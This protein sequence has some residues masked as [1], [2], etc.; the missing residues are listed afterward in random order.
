M[1]YSWGFWLGFHAVLFTL[2][3]L[4]LFLFRR[5]KRKEGIQAALGWSCFWIALSLA[6]NL[7]IY[8]MSGSESAL[9][10]FTGYVIE[11]SLSIDN[12]FVFLLIF[13]SLKI[14][15]EHQHKIL[16]GGVFGALVFRLCLILLGVVGLEK[17][18]W[19]YY[20][21]GSFLCLTA[22]RFALDA[23]EKRGM[24]GNP[25]Y[26]LAVR[27]LPLASDVREG[28]FFLR[29]NGKLFMTSSFL[30]LILI[31]TA[32]IIFALDSIPAILAIT[33]NPF[34]VY[35]SNIFAILGLRSLYFV[36]A[37]FQERMR[38]FTLG[39]ALILF[40]IGLKMLLSSWVVVS[41]GLSL[42]VILSILALAIVFSVYCPLKKE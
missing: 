40:F 7:F 24:E 33:T 4:D 3:S 14:P 34:I 41:V 30:A 15:K 1:V 23:K 19:M 25:I 35:T 13:S 16:Y 8:W 12:I 18:S 9:L 38:F 36:L 31:E 5:G 37:Y 2:L 21:L 6:F 27:F 10:F 29:R 39:L 26:K 17:Y 28:N 32:D 11:K 22:V 20:V 42:A